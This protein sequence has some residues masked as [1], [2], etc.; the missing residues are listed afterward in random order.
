MSDADEP[1]VIELAESV[2]R[3]ERKAVEVLDE[4]LTRIEA[5]NERL[6]A[7][8]HLDADLAR[9]AAAA[10]DEAVAR[11]DDP[12]PLAGVPFG[13]KDL[14]RCK[15]MPT[16]YGSVPFAGRGP[17]PEDDINVARLKAAGA[18]AV[19]KTST[20]EFGTLNFTKT[21]VHGITR[22]PWDTSRTPGGSSGGTA[23]AVAAGIIPFGTASDGGGSIR[24]PAS[25]T[26]LLGHKCSHGRIPIPGPTGNNTSVRGSLT[27]T[28][29][30]TARILDVLAGPDDRDRFSLPPAG[31]DYEDAIE[32]TRRAR[33]AGAVVARSRLRHRRSGGGR[34]RRGGSE[35][36][37]RRSRSRRRRTSRCSS[38]IRC[39]RG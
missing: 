19:G 7:F 29:A 11:G 15:G 31:I 37:R 26:G 3:G 27:T 25:F 30:D 4:Y 17:E 28:V 22:N 13:V 2:R 20:P 32:S 36:T 21:K 33:A 38:P 39:A 8:V 34:D 5:G 1:T 18:V 24:I 12:G 10:V 9:E 6:N 14:E 23:A 35:S 16:D